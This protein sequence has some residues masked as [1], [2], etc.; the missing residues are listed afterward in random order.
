MENKKDIS[1]D[2]ISC[3]ARKNWQYHIRDWI[4][5]QRNHA[6]M[7]GN[8]EFNYENI[9]YA[10]GIAEGITKMWGGRVAHTG[11]ISKLD[12]YWLYNHGIG[13]KLPLSNKI[14]N[15]ELYK[16]SLNLLKLYHRKGNAI[17]TSVDE[18]SKRLKNDFPYY[19][20]EASCIQDVDSLKKLKKKI[21][22]G[23]YDTIVLPIHMNDDIKFLES[24]KEKEKIRLFLNAECSYNCP[25]KVC[26]GG[27]ST[28][29]TNKS[30]IMLC[31]FYDLGLERTFYNDEI[32]WSEYYFNKLKFNKMGFTKYKLVPPTEQQQR[33]FIMYEKNKNYPKKRAEDI[34]SIKSYTGAENILNVLQ[35]H[36]GYSKKD[37]NQRK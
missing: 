20:I 24:I 16:E 2:K 18:F 25:K 34:S 23:C 27:T 32:N 9:D 35:S 30:N 5:L 10:F 19:Q 28:V 1:M 13:L 8:L 33:T 14:F 11:D 12:E 6:K 3:S 7:H 26:Y 21:S 15:D 31:S 37:T 22:L 29:N 4:D 36:I 17:I